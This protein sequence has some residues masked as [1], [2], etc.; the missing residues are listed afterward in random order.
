MT[1][2]LIAALPRMTRSARA[3]TDELF[4]AENPDDGLIADVVGLVADAGGI[5]EYAR[6]W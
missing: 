1:L 4:A 6:P 5:E 2:P 3:R